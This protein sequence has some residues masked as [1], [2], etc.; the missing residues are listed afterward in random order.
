M[1]GYWDLV[2]SKVVHYVETNL[3]SERIFDKGKIIFIGLVVFL[4]FFKVIHSIIT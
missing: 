4:L 2:K 3:E 1:K